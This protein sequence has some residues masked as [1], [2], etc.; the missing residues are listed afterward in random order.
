VKIFVS[1]QRVEGKIQLVGQSCGFHLQIKLLHQLAK[2][3]IY[4]VLGEAG[5]NLENRWKGLVGS[6]RGAGATPPEMGC[7]TIAVS[8]SKPSVR[9]P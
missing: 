1:A 6:W 4:M 5:V 7:Q 3:H 8:D 9:L 2:H